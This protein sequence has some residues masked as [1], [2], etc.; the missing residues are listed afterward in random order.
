MERK[1]HSLFLFTALF[2]SSVTSFAQETFTLATS[3][4]ELKVGDL[5]V[6]VNPEDSVAMAGQNNNNR[7]TTPV[8]INNGILTFNDN[9]QIL[10]LGGGTGAWTFYTGEGY[11]YA[12]GSKSNFLRTETDLDDNAKA[13]VTIGN[14]GVAAITFQGAN[15]RNRLLYNANNSI[16]S[17][18]GSTTSVNGTVQ[19][20]RR[21]SGASPSVG[22]VTSISAF[23]ALAEGATTELYLSDEINARVVYCS[24]DTAMLKDDTGIVMIVGIP[25]NPQFTFG[26]HVA[27]YIHGE[28]SSSDGIPLFKATSKT[29]T[30]CFVIAKAVTE[31]DVDEVTPTKIEGVNVDKTQNGRIYDFMGRYMG[32]DLELIPAGA[33]IRNGKKIIV[34]K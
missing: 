25:T 23:N 9:V 6:I 31:K 19:L 4:N 14:D 27:G 3:S 18:Y 20:Y 22:R 15:T 7:A 1:L 13:S 10:T 5:L 12:A 32:K 26:A 8:H 11:L 29:N 21:S 16:F 2:M 34:S 17:C 33:Y 28:R 24:N 30:A